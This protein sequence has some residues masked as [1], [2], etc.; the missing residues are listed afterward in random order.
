MKP[1]SPR[2]ALAITALCPAVL[3]APP[4]A[5]RDWDPGNP[6]TSRLPGEVKGKNEPS[7]GD[8]VYERFDAPLTLGVHAGV[9]A[10]G[11]VTAAS[12]R[13]VAHYYFTAGVYAAYSEALSEESHGARWLSLGLDLQPAFLPRW[14]QD[15]EQGPGRLDLLLDSI[16]LGLGAYF[17]SPRHGSLGDERGFELS[18]GVGLPLLPTVTGPWLGARG[19]LR[20]GDPSPRTQEPSA[21][22]SALVTVGYKWLAGG[23]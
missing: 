1:P 20:F 10:E 13:L 4:P 9:E 16:S 7:R 17:L 15:L 19:Q 5:P 22:A 3:G 2:I 21:E 18:L 6:T 14:S 11:P 12:G 8:G 23:S